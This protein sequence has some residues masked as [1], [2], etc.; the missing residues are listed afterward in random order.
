MTG[1][2]V[3]I[4]SCSLL[5]TLLLHIIPSSGLRYVYKTIAPD[6]AFF[7]KV[8]GPVVQS[9]I[10]LTSSSVVKMLTALESTYL[11]HSYFC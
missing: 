1:A 3:P 5:T 10:S 7:R 8:Q 4:S 2:H 9:I 11:I 6:K